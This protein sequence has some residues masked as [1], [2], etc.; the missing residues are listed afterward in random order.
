MNAALIRVGIDHSYGHW[1]APADPKTRDFFF[2]PIPEKNTQL[3]FHNNSGRYY[4]ELLPALEQFTRR[5]GYNLDDDLRFPRDALLKGPMHLDPDFE[6]LTYGNRAGRKGSVLR[7]LTEDDLVVFFA[8]MRST[9]PKDKQLIYGIIGILV[10][11]E[12]LDVDQIP[13]G[14][15]H[16]N[17]HTRKIKR[18]GDDIVIW[19]KPGVSGRLSRFIPIGEYRNRAYRV[20]RDLLKSWG[21]LSVND[22]YIQRSAVP[23]TFSDPKR[24]YSWFKK[25]NVPL[26]RS[27]F[28]QASSQ[29]VIIVHLRQPRRSPGERRDDPFY[30]FGSFGCTGCH[31][32]N[33]MNPKRIHELDGVRV[34]FAQGGAEGTKLILLTPPIQAIRHPNVCELNWQPTPKPFRYEAAPLLIDNDGETDFPPL[35]ESMR[36]ANRSTWCGKLSSCFR[37]SRTPLP[38]LVTQSLIAEYERRGDEAAPSDFVKCYADTMAVPPPEVDRERKK[39]YEGLL[40]KAGAKTGRSSRCG[41]GGSKKSDRRNRSSGRHRKC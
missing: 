2:V 37:S 15:W 34:A 14:K 24:F 32:S 17:A 26:L 40:K 28:G 18:G 22:G 33:L 27:N 31:R 21:G 4:D 10:V 19:G 1:N 16:E 39:R 38:D 36:A 30:E 9:E 35:K 8:G 20:R 6:Y 23:P 5:F 7:K 13:K 25:Q 11:A 12:V 3:K 29:K 41:P